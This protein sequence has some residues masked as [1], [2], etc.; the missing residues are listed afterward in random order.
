MLQK[1]GPHIQRPTP[2][3]V[4]WARQAAIVKS[5]DDVGPLR[6]AHPEAIR[7]FRR[8]FADQSPTRPAGAIANDILDALAGYR[9]PRLYV[10]MHNE[11]AR[12]DWR[13]HVDQWRAATAILHDAGVLVVGP[14]WAT[15]DYE[16]D[17]WEALRGLGWLGFD[18]IGVHC[19]WS[20][21]GFTP[22]NALRY[23]SYWRPDD[24]PIIITECGRDRVRDGNAAHDDG[25]LP[26]RD[27]ANFGFRAQSLDDDAFLAEIV[28][29]DREITADA[30]VLG[31]TIFTAGAHQEWRDKGFDID[32]LC[33]RL[34]ALS[35]PPTPPRALE[36]APPPPP[37]R[38]TP[39]PAAAL[40]SS[41][42]LYDARARYPELA[43]RRYP[44]RRL[45]EIS[46][47]VVHHSVTRVP[48]TIEDTLAVLDAIN[49]W[50]TSG[51]SEEPGK[52]HNWPSIG[53]TF[54]ISGR[55][56]IVQLHDLDIASYHARA[57]N[58]TGVGVCLLGDFS[59]SPP[60]AP[61]VNAL[62]S[63]Y[64][65][66]AEQVG[67]GIALVGH[68]EAPGN[69]DTECPGDHWVD[70]RASVMRLVRPA[71]PTREETVPTPLDTVWSA[72]DALEREAARL[73][74]AARNDDQRWLADALLAHATALKGLVHANKRITEA[75]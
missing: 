75:T 57:A 47:V 9:H 55:G 26:Q 45:D 7:V 51:S 73:K 11:I 43:G 46:S 23:R 60:P 20:T 19:Y 38:P 24:P 13:R 53:Y 12:T 48:M 5:V 56:H 59:D 32:S 49:V 2:E 21:A 27:G 3:G 22:W 68:R 74:P 40:P 65:H 10:E 71:Q 37:R 61:M 66:I 72:A 33:A 39:T 29:Y 44:R 28:A 6:D 64:R 69:G 31:A 18:A 34:A 54:A 52:P 41:Q 63:V 62:A 15:G 50:H 1:T 42:G 17:D 35:A 16:A 36:V 4:G 25:W 14:N 30:S 8:F 58:R 70:T 67:N